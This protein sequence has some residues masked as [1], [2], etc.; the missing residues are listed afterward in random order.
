MPVQL[1]KTLNFTINM[2][3]KLII[4]KKN[5]MAFLQGKNCPFRNPLILPGRIAGQLNVQPIPCSNDCPLFNY[6]DSGD[7]ISGMVKLSCANSPMLIMVEIEKI[8]TISHE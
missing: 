3:Q 2:K 1:L 4:D 7:N 8:N 5:N 6:H